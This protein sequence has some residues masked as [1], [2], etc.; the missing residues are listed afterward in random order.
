M[1]QR[2]LIRMGCGEVSEH[3]VDDMAILEATSSVALVKRGI[4]IIA[5]RYF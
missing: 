5:R 2:M 3:W 4:D 1:V